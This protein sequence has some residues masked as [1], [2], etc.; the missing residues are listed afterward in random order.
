MDLTYLSIISFILITVVYYALP[1][2]GKMS[3]TLKMFT[4]AEEMDTFNQE[5]N[6]RLAIYLAVVLLS[7]FIINT[8]FVINACGG[9]SVSNY[10]S[11]FLIT[12]LPWI[13]IFGVMLIA[14]IM[15]PG[16]KGAFSDVV[17]YFFV[18]DKANTL[19]SQILMSDTTAQTAINGITDATVKSDLT[20]AAESII[21]LVGNKAILINQITPL[22]FISTWDTLKQLM[23]PTMYENE[24]LKSELLD[25][26]VM[27]ENVGEALWYIYTGLLIISYTSYKITSASCPPDMNQ[28]IKKKVTNVGNT[29]SNTATNVAPKVTKVSNKIEDKSKNVGNKASKIAKNEVAPRAVNVGNRASN[30]ATNEVAPIA[31]NI[32]TNELAPIATNTIAPRAT[33]VG[34]RAS[35]IATNKVGPRAVNSANAFASNASNV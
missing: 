5:S 22:N 25:L 33:N 26:A 31:S 11:A 2:I 27:R 19:L 30:I 7:Q 16:F 20:R 12:F 34:N 10:G 14:L 23:K 9:S 4:N 35:N 6:I 18:S 15:Y 17:G 32:A 29:V 24:Q 1:S 13:F 8:T 21:K 3:A 28:V